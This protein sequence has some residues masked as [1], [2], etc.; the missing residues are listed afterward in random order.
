[1]V[2]LTTENKMDTI[3]QLN[4]V[5]QFMNVCSQEV[6]TRETYQSTKIADFR[7]RLI[8][9]EIYG[10]NELVDSVNDDNIVGIVDGL[11]DILYVVYGAI[12]TFG[13]HLND[14]K[15]F[16]RTSGT[17]NLMH[18]HVAHTLLRDL[19]SAF[20]QYK[21]GVEIGDFTT[22]SRGLTGMLL[23]V[24]RIAEA[25]N[26]DII[27]AFDE[28]HASNMSKVCS[29]DEQAQSSIAKRIAKNSEKSKEYIGANVVKVEV[30]G[31]EYFVI[32][33][34]SDNKVLKGDG[35]FEPDLSKF[36]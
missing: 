25:S 19:D 30:D 5:K 8:D 4:L 28:V 14:Y 10:K 1:M 32:C 11:C 3:T 20:Q 31:I 33:R 22:I 36:A 27:G 35:F 12:A 9:E 6:N 16:Q 15:L 7:T 2:M 13:T 21:R 29:S 17:G 34:A 24:N 23:E 18:K 26:I